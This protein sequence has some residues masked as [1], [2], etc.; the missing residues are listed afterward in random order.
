MLT[1]QFIV[2]NVI[3][4][5]RAVRVQWPVDSYVR[6]KTND[7][8]LITTSAGQTYS[9]SETPDDIEALVALNGWPTLVA[10][11]AGK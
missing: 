2:L 3:D 6:N 10:R 7:A 9:V 5:P 11:K 1:P 4:V 8:T